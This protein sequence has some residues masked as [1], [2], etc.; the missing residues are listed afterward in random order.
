MANTNTAE[1]PLMGSIVRIK[2]PIVDVRYEGLECRLPKIYDQLTVVDSAGTS[3]LHLEVEAHLGDNTVRTIA[4]GSTQGLGRTMKVQTSNRPIQVPV[5]E[6]VLGTVLNVLG[7]IV[8]AH[9]HRAPVHG[10][11][12]QRPIVK[13][14]PNLWD[15]RSDLTIFPTYI[16][17]IDLFSPLPRGGKVGFFGGAGVGKTV[18]LKELMQNL[19]LED[20]SPDRSHSRRV[21]S[22]FAGIGER[23]REGNE[24][25]ED[26]RNTDIFKRMCLIYGQMNETPGVRMRAANTA[27]TIA[28]ELRKHGDDVVMFIDNIFRY[29]QAGSEVST[30]LGKMPSEVGYQPTLEMEIGDLQERLVSTKEGSITA[31]QAVYVPADDITDPASAALFSHLDAFIV[32]KR[33]IAEKGLYPA[34]DLLECTSRALTREVVESSAEMFLRSES[35]NYR[36]H[37]S[38]VT[39]VMRDIRGQF[40]ED[41]LTQLL[42]GHME[43]ARR[44]RNLL[45]KS[46]EL[47]NKVRLLGVDS[48][49]DENEN[50]ERENYERADRLKMFMTQDFCTTHQFGHQVPLWETLYG[51]LV[52]LTAPLDRFKDIPTKRFRGK[53]ALS[54]VEGTEELMKY[55]TQVS[56]LLD[57]LSEY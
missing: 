37:G 50:N 47:E 48:L 36:E 26:L 54:T 52:I 30:L 11:V 20:P 49:S 25:W 24:D 41:G 46:V 22:V 34:V 14:P 39:H 38:P 45:T 32:M 18:F 44:A 15:L 51:A 35:V 6:S 7:E 40:G 13:E 16:K 3:R 1:R 19:M 27:A 4:L 55:R 12:V 5:G 29:V 31:I 53:G 8:Y 23:T 33:S 28:E 42:H 2:G 43:I 21:T 10:A 56:N 9:P 57:R 17:A